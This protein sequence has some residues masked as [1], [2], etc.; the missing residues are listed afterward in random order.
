MDAVLRHSRTLDFFHVAT[1]V[2]RGAM[3]VLTFGA[4]QRVLAIHARLEFPE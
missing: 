3:R 1:A 4:R 2:H